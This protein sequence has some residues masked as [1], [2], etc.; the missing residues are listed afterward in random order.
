MPIE[1]QFDKTRRHARLAVKGHAEAIAVPL[2]IP[3]TGGEQRA[4]VTLPNG[5]EYREVD[6]AQTAV[7]RG[8]G[9]IRFDHKGT[10]SNLALVDHTPQGLA[11]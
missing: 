9:Q 7:L 1:W 3:A 5:F 8:I 11:A 4:I 6:V 2:V 10:N